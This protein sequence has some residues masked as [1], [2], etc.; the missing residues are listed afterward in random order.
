MRIEKVKIKIARF[1]EYK[2]QKQVFEY[3]VI[4]LEESGYNIENKS[5]DN[6]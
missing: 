1:P 6:Y 4:Q 3:F 2:C 5:I